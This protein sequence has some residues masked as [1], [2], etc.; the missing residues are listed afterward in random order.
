M[1]GARVSRERKQ[2]AGA[3]NGRGCETDRKTAVPTRADE[4]CAVSWR[5]GAP[6]A[7][8]LTRESSSFSAS[9]TVDAFVRLNV[10]SPPPTPWT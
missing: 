3:R 1:I 6:A 4:Q 7:L 10:I 5:T 8:S 9:D 2:S